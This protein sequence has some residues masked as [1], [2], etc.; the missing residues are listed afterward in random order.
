MPASSVRFSVDDALALRD[1]AT[2]STGTANVD[3]TSDELALDV[4]TAYWDGSNPANQQQFV[5]F[6][7]VTGIVDSGATLTV[8]VSATG[9]FDDTVTLHTLVVT[10]TGAFNFGILREQLAAQTALRVVATKADGTSGADF[11]AYAAPLPV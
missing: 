11:W 9:D 6:G 5:I 10:A 3:I 2:A 1:T 8:E 7:S 4:L